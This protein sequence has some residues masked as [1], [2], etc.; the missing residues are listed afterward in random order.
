[1]QR[2]VLLLVAWLISV[3][4]LAQTAAPAAPP[5]TVDSRAECVALGGAWL[6]SRQSWLAVCQVPW[7]RDDCLHLGGGWTP[8]TGVAGG[9][10]CTAQV[11]DRATSRQC[12]ESGGTWGPPSSS[13]PYCQPNTVRAKAP[14]KKAS[15]A[16]HACDGQA[17]CVYGCIYKGAPVVIGASVKG[18]CRATNQ[19]EGCDAMVESG[20]YV[21]SI[22]KR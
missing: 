5:V 15:D 1:M 4:A 11:S 16:N 20:R 14:V 3:A 9:G 8:N 22:C 2:L 13:M 6:A 19:V 17:D 21:G 10:F 18:V 7:G 12:T